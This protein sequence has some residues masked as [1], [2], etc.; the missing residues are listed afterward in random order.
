MRR[1]AARIACVPIIFIHAEPTRGSVPI[2]MTT[3]VCDRSR[4][5]LYLS[6]SLPLLISLGSCCPT[7]RH[8]VPP[9]PEL[10]ADPRMLGTWVRT[11]K[12]GPDVSKEQ[13]SIFQRRSGWID[14]VWIYAIDSPVSADGIT[15]LILEGYNTSVNKQRFLC[16]RPR[17]KDHHR[18]AE[19]VAEW[20]FAMV[21]YETPSKDQLIIKLFSVQKV[22]EL[23]KKGTLKGEIVK[24]GVFKGLPLED[25]FRQ[26]L[27]DVLKGQSF[28]EVVVTSSSDELVEVISREGVGAFIGQGE[29]DI[30]V[31]S[32]GAH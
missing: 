20:P 10:K 13:L 31:L 12:A 6:L 32:R 22:E 16:F 23:V 19:E 17:G 18:S 26:S 7:F 21:N 27:D 14:V 2:M 9:P 30:L 1:N 8:P 24:K 28:D 5:S 3:N 15:V 29:N 11:T 25:A 4:G